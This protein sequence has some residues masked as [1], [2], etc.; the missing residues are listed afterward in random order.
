MSLTQRID[1]DGLQVAESLER[2]LADEA[3]PGSG[4][5]AAP[6]WKGFSALVHE[7]AP[8]NR[9]LLAERDRLQSELDAWHRE[10]MARKIAPLITAPARQ[11][12]DR[13]RNDL[14][15]IITATN[16]FITA[17]IARQFGIDELIATEA[18]AIDGEFTGN[19]EG[20]PC[21]RE[22]KPVRLQQWLAAR[23]Q[24]LEQFDESW[25]YSDSANDLPL[26]CAVSH[27]VAV[28]PDEPLARYATE[29]AWQTIRF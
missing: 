8:R 7:M 3:L 29:H 24:T 14:C 27:P 1:H 22:G 13:H 25:F 21:F 23:G 10:F 26:L 18:Q 4:V 11:M 2:F 9:A 28:N 5:D 19:V 20:V 15:A 17:P 12:V 6:F 16:R